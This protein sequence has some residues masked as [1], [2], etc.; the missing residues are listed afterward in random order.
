VPKSSMAILMP[1]AFKR[2]SSWA[3]RWVSCMS[4]DSVISSLRQA[5]SSPVSASTAVTCS[6]SP[7]LT[8]CRQETLTLTDSPAASGIVRCQDRNWR[9]ASLMTKRPM[10][11]IRPVSSARG[12]NRAG[13]MMPRWGW[14][15]RTR[16]SKPSSAPVWT[17]TMGW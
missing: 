7:S 17:E 9:H 2:P 5:G 11:R 8:N 3:V 15:Q 14:F 12:M 6:T 1:R 10:G 4:T 13:G 16:A